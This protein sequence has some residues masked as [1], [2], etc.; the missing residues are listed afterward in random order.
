MSFNE[1]ILDC[2]AL[3]TSPMQYEW[4]PYLG[5]EAITAQ[6]SPSRTCS[7]WQC[8][9]RAKPQ[10]RTREAQTPSQCPTGDINYHPCDSNE[11]RLSLCPLS[12]HPHATQLSPSLSFLSLWAFIHYRLWLISSSFRSSASIWLASVRPGGFFRGCSNGQWTESLLLFKWI[13]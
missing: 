6:K 5:C 12:I 1:V 7:W 4:W 3:V 2:P 9:S 11:M 10:Q 8:S 13:H